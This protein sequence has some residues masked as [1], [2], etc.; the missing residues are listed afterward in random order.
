MFRFSRASFLS[1][2]QSYQLQGTDIDRLIGYYWEN[3]GIKIIKNGY[4]SAEII[5]EKKQ[6]KLI[7]VMPTIE[8]LRDPKKK[9]ASY[10]QLNFLPPGETK[11]NY[12][13][14]S[15]I[16]PPFWKEYLEITQ[17][18]K[19]FILP[20]GH[21]KSN[22]SD[23]EI[24]KL[25]KIVSQLACK[26]LLDQQIEYCIKSLQDVCLDKSEIQQ[27]IE[28]IRKTLKQDEQVGYI[29]T[30]NTDKTREHIE[31][32]ILSKQAIIKP[33]TWNYFVNS[34]ISEYSQ[35]LASDFFNTPLYLPD[36]SFFNKENNLIKKLPHPQADQTSC[37][38]LCL[39]FLKKLLEKNALELNSLTLYFSFYN[40][41]Q[42]KK[43]FFLP[44]PSLLMHSQ[45]SG[46]INFLTKIMGDTSE[47]TYVEDHEIKPIYTLKGLLIDSVVKAR[48]NND[49]EMVNHNIACLNQLSTLRPH[50]F[51]TAL[52]AIEKRKKM[53][54]PSS[55]KNLYL[56]YRTKKLEN[57]AFF[58]HAETLKENAE[59]QMTISKESALQYK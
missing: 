41:Q 28:E 27:E 21:L 24:S 31:C 52:S 23:S 8:K 12:L 11:Q 34:G 18:I 10:L 36:L 56:M 37:G 13:C 6:K 57:I 59:N 46:Y 42:Q 49:T 58:S 48:K 55:N 9:Y 32:L 3:E 22:L 38:T 47:V 54:D 44:S 53:D 16:S 40:Y 50:W 33:I 19:H 45:S 29:F 17:S 14:I 1:A 51:K 4:K 43:Y 26:S 7:Q 35:L 20:N 30:N 39:S 2:H 5:A 25:N 15:T